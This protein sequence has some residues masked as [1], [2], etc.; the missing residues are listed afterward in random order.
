MT[1]TWSARPSEFYE[2]KSWGSDGVI[3]LCDSGDTHLLNPM[4]V[5]ALE[6]L[7]SSSFQLIDLVR[8][9]SLSPALDAE[10]I[11][12]NSVLGLLTELYYLGILSKK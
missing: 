8:E 6:L 10:S 2:F 3:F 5:Q 7:Q 1:E 9:L 4:G 11:T 12:P